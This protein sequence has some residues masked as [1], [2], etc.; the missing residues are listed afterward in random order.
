M[1]LIYSLP[2]VSHGSGYVSRES[3]GKSVGLLA[4]PVLQ[5]LTVSPSW[6]CTGAPHQPSACLRTQDCVP[7]L[8]PQSWPC[9]PLGPWPHS[10]QPPGDLV[11]GPTAAKVT[12]CNGRVGR[13]WL[14]AGECARDPLGEQPPDIAGVKGRAGSG[15]WGLW[16]PRSFPPCSLLPHSAWNANLL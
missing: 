6:P 16:G 9:R 12:V 10:L 2:L 11:P 15:A 8:L 1:A 7:L 5:P 14:K 4:P 3:T 13:G